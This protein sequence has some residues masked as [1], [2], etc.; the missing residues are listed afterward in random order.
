MKRHLIL[1][2]IF[3]LA[4]AAL[5]DDHGDSRSA[6][7][8]VAP[9]STTSGHLDQGDRDY[10]R[11]E[12]TAAG[13]LALSS[14]SGID[15]VGRLE[16]SRGA[17]IITDNNSG[18]GKNFR[19]V[20]DLEPGLY[21]LLVRGRK[22]AAGAYVLTADFVLLDDH[23]NSRS[24]ATQ[25][26][27]ES[28]TAG[29]LERTGDVDY[30][31]IPVG[32]AGLLVVA[33]GGDTDTAGRLEQ[34]DGTVLAADD[35]AGDG[36]NFRIAHNVGAG[37]HYV[38]VSGFND[39]RTGE[40]SLDVS[41]TPAPT[42]EDGDLRLAGGSDTSGRLEILHNGKWGTICDD[43]FGAPDAA[44][45]CRQLGFARATQWGRSL[46][47]GTG[48][49][50]LDDL[51]C[52]GTESHL[53]QCPHAGF[54]NN[55]CIHFEDVAVTCADTDPAPVPDPDPP[56]TPDPDPD[57]TP[58]PDPVTVEIST[59]TTRIF[60]GRGA[61]LT[62]TRR[63][64]ATSL[65]APLNVRFQVSETGDMLFRPLPTNINIPAESHVVT[66]RVAT[67]DD[68][69]GETDSTVT[70]T[71]TEGEGYEV[72]SPA[73]ASFL[74][75]D[76]DVP[77]VAGFTLV[78]ASTGADVQVLTDGTVVNLT[79]ASEDL[80]GIRADMISS[81]AGP[82]RLALVGEGWTH[83]HTPDAAPYSLFGTQDGQIVGREFPAGNYHIGAR[84]ES[85]APLSL[86]FTIEY[87]TPPP[88]E[89]PES[90]PPPPQEGDLRLAD[91]SKTSG[92][93][94]ILHNGKWG[95]ICDDA[96]GAPDA[97]VAC[98]QLGFARATQWGRSLASGTG[99]IWLDDLACTGAESHLDQCSHPGFGNHNCIHFEDVAVTCAA[100]EPEPTPT[101]DPPTGALVDRTSGT[102]LRF[103]WDPPAGTAT[104]ALIY[105]VCIAAGTADCTP[106]ARRY[107]RPF[108]QQGTDRWHFHLFGDPNGGADGLTPGTTYRMC[109][110]ARREDEFSPTVCI[111]GATSGG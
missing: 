30:F 10:F 43:K 58:D 45:A 60:E 53:Y 2:P 111:T 25:V 26:S 71:V 72:G 38:A 3:L 98:R 52:T 23:G 11:I 96:F 109:V 48:Q 41:F 106:A 14:S 57:P 99:R 50:W 104:G 5:A 12:L 24:E 27:V 76:N 13:T 47:S 101:L 36:D 108:H 49:I 59:D 75:A 37:A 46:A 89:P 81:G 88:P 73:A 61:S 83:L 17:R 84:P 107:A 7:T 97:A 70:I 69:V 86:S 110:L 62:L 51:A 44:V 66:L 20:R 55:N 34:G 16:D 94:E 67:V 92:R 22:G 74:V 4:A 9:T 65:S 103:N 56:P 8:P 79:D 18:E 64:P 95:T 42:H 28:S 63:G 85:G 29:S 39:A 90:D 40:Y 15:T 102:H 35:D 19:V 82:V 54:G 32:E 105:D 100:P 31:R 91:G 77:V 68:A 33:S 80:F 21:Y 78:N 87:D 6:A 93:L 1:T